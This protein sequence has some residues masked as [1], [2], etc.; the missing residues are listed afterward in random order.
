MRRYEIE[1][2]LL[3]STSDRAGARVRLSSSQKSGKLPLPR[4][5][6]GSLSPRRVA[7]RRNFSAALSLSLPLSISGIGAL[8]RVPSAISM[9]LHPA[10]VQDARRNPTWRSR[11]RGGRRRTYASVRLPQY[12]LAPMSPHLPPLPSIGRSFHI[13]PCCDDALKFEGMPARSLTP[14]PLAARLLHHFALRRRDEVRGSIFATRS[15]PFPATHTH[16]YT[17]THA[18]V[19]DAYANGCGHIISTIDAIMGRNGEPADARR[20]RS[21]PS[22]QMRAARH[23]RSPTPLA[24]RILVDKPRRRRTNKQA[25]RGLIVF[26]PEGRPRITLRVVC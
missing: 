16:T 23:R 13:R 17:H 9:T 15:D 3:E 20:C 24:F 25:L 5:N 7:R 21:H 8:E 2:R 19:R 6:S 1:R 18:H 10:N 22:C 14:S 4:V 11:S 12:V 26:V